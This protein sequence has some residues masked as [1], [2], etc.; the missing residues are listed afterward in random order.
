MAYENVE[1]RSNRM[2]DWRAEGKREYRGGI[3]NTEDL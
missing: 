2:V 3:T 1:S